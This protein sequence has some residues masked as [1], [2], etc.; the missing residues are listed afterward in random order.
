M[1]GRRN[2]LPLAVTLCQCEDPPAPSLTV[3]DI[4]F[5]KTTCTCTAFISRHFLPQHV[6]FPHEAFETNFCFFQRRFCGLTS[7][8]I[9]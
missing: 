4:S 1:T 2:S 6:I 7:E 5:E 8:N 3:G 9:P